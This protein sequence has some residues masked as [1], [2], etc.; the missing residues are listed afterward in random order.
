MFDN[1]YTF[2]DDAEYIINT[3]SANKI[4]KLLNERIEK[5][6]KTPQNYA[7]LANAY[8][9]KGQFSNALKCAL[10]AKSLDENYYYAD[11]ILAMIYID[12]ENISKA[13][14]YLSSLL[15]KCTE[16]YYFAYY[17][18][19]CLYNMKAEYDIVQ[20]Y[21]NKLK[22]IN[23]QEPF[24]DT[25]KALA[26]FLEQDYKNILKYSISALKMKH[27]TFDNTILLLG[28][29]ISSGIAIFFKNIDCS[30]VFSYFA[31]LFLRKDEKYASLSDM[32]L[33]SDLEKALKNINKAIRIN[34]RPTYFIHKSTIFV[35]NNNYKK[36]INILEY[37]IKNNPEYTYL[38][39]G[40]SNLY[41]KI[42]DD[43]KA[44]E[45]ANLDLLNNMHN[46]EKYHRKF[47]IL[48]KM[49]R[50]DECSNIL[51]KLEKEFPTGDTI[52]YNR[53]QIFMAKKE[54]EKAI[55][56]MNKLLLRGKNDLYLIDK[57]YCLF[58]MERYDEAIDI[59]LQIMAEKEKGIVCFWLAR[60][61]LALENFQTALIYMNKSILLGDC[62]MWNYYWKSVILE[63]LGRN[64]EAEITYQK[65]INLGYS[66]DS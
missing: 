21:S 6:Q 28:L 11:F 9:N 41:E 4:V 39:A 17:A 42:N 44:L 3:F 27:K 13:E 37:V 65:A 64:N 34:P 14:K 63:N 46:P 29:I 5:D 53:A 16:D 15:E 66:E 18:A 32:F 12:E 60:S 43:K 58:M 10:K 7:F 56:Y 2:Y 59:G 47:D 50:Y 33:S 31:T 30:K 1:I 57:M 36:A 23:K 45:Y 52:E 55:L 22:Q 8:Y 49:Q 61:Y 24:C 25:L 62:D 19:V 54:Y 26:C 20:K 51:D 35:M 38:Y 48:F 40:L